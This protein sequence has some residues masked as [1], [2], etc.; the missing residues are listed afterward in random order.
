MFSFIPRN[1][2]EKKSSVNK[3]DKENLMNLNYQGFYSTRKNQM[4]LEVL[5]QDIDGKIYQ[6][7]SFRFCISPMSS[8]YA[9]FKKPL[10]HI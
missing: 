6:I 4:V 1:Q 2:E 8:K 9:F 3:F 7:S 10:G 5:N